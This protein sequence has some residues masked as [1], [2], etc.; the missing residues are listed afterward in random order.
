MIIMRGQINPFSEVSRGGSEIIGCMTENRSPREDSKIVGC[1]GK[2]FERH[3]LWGQNRGSTLWFIPSPILTYL[4][5]K[6]QFIYKIFD[7]YSHPKLIPK[8]RLFLIF[9]KEFWLNSNL[10]KRRVSIW[11]SIYKEM[12]LTYTLLKKKKKTRF[13]YCKEKSILLLEKWFLQGKG[14]YLC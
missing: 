2:P 9:L 8:I 1:I 11:F 6:F 12:I 3:V 10:L 7:F 14:V 13:H 5:T 4:F